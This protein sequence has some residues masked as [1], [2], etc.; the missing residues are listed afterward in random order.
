MVQPRTGLDMKKKRKAIVGNQK[1]K[2]M[3]RR[4]RL[5][6]FLPLTVRK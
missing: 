4:E 6:S 3:G 1:G 5:E 2:I